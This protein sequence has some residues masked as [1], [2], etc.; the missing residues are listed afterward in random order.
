MTPPQ[1]NDQ[2]SREQFEQEM[3][4]FAQY[5]T[6]AINDQLDPNRGDS[7]KVLVPNDFNDCLVWNTDSVVSELIGT[8]GAIR[9]M[10]K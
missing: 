5:L 4:E 9:K 2:T 7:S 3:R 10:K 8:E 1:V 6:K